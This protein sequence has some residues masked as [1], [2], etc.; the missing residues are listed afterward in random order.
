[1][2]SIPRI[3]Y[4]A[5]AGYSRSPQ[6]AFSSEELGWFEESRTEPETRRNGLR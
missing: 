1:M 2:N 5:L 6:T 3:R 4:D